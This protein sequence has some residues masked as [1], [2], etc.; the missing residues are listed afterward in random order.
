M[1]MMTGV[2][3]TP[4]ALGWEGGEGQDAQGPWD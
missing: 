4:P 2:S 3:D 1:A